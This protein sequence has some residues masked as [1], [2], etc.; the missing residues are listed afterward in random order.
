L[1]MTRTRRFSVFEQ[2]AVAF[3]VVWCAQP[4]TAGT[5]GAFMNSAGF[6]KAA[7]SI[8]FNGK[9]TSVTSPSGLDPCAAVNPQQFTCATA[10][11]LPAGTPASVYCQC[12]GFPNMVWHIQTY[13]TAGATADNPELD[14]RVT[15]IPTTCPASYMLDSSIGSI[16]EDTKSGSINVSANVTLGA[17]LWLRGFELPPGAPAPGSV[18]DLMNFGALKW[19][20]LLIGPFDSTPAGNGTTCSTLT[21]PFTTQTGISNLYFVVDAEAKTIPFVV[22]CPDIVFCVPDTLVYPEPQVVSGGCGSMTVTYDPPADSL[23]LGPTLVTAT[24]TDGVGNTAQC[25]FTA[26]RKAL[27]FN[28][29]GAPI[30]GIG[31]SPLA[32][33]STLRLKKLGGS[34]DVQFACDCNSSAVTTGTATLAIQQDISPR[35]TGPQVFR[36]VGGGNFTF[37]ASANAWQFNWN[38]TSQTIGIYKLIA[39]LPDGSQQ[40]AVIK[41]IN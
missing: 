17:A 25:T 5:Q 26:T 41:L 39:T 27:S 6:G 31:G 35:L 29:F 20:T 34:L 22:S 16:S 4:V 12:K 21:I 38:I 37:N 10:G 32:P 14:S 11:N 33:C 15:I 19:D 13:V 18:T 36:S 2:A 40:S 7:A 3:M 24:V 9:A 8:S 23:P 1:I 30:I 28:G